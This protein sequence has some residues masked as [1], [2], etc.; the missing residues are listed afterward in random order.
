MGGG[1]C[2]LTA[3]LGGEALFPDMPTKGP[4]CNSNIT[5]IRF[6]GLNCQGRMM[7]TTG[8]GDIKGECAADCSLRFFRRCC[9]TAALVTMQRRRL[10]VGL[11][12]N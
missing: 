2:V 12:R 4:C 8:R 5:A 1:P 11:E 3:V 7:A 9:G 6:E 10:C